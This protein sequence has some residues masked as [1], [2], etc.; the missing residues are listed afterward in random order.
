MQPYKGLHTAY[1]VIDA[2]LNWSPIIYPIKDI[3]L[4]L[5]PTLVLTL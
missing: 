2:L 3:F 4:T 1:N 5:P